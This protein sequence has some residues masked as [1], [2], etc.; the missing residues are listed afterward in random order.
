MEDV[1]PSVSF[2]FVLFLIVCVSFCLMQLELTK[3]KNKK[4]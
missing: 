1:Q 4:N 3:N 2:G